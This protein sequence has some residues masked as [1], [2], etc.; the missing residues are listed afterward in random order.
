M[1][2]WSS[3]W[4]N[5]HGLMVIRAPVLGKAMGKPKDNNVAWDSSAM[6]FG[7]TGSISI[8]AEKHHKN[9][10]FLQVKIYQHLFIAFFLT[11]VAV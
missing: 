1:A 9:L 5:P 4:G 6:C 8:G 2:S 10:L 7:K 3:R 11:A